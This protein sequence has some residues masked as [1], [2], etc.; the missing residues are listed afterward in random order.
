MDGSG[1]RAIADSEGER[2]DFTAI[3]AALVAAL[4]SGG[5]M[6]LWRAQ[7][8]KTEAEADKTEAEGSAVLAATALSMVKRWEV[9]VLD[10]EKRVGEL[11]TENRQL[12]HEVECL[13]KRVD[14]LEAENCM[15]RQGA[16]LLQGQV[17][18]LGA[19]PIWRVPEVWPSQ[20]GDYGEKTD[21]ARGG[22]E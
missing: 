2:M 7:H 21:Q 6:F 19:S 9:R 18:D 17:V 12:S 8:H 14:T 11:E 4:L 13:G 20:S 22:A 1:A 10:L 15:L 3:I 16:L 5:G